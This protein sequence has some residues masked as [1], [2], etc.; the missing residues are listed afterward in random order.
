M[1]LHTF[2]RG[3]RAW[4]KVQTISAGQAKYEV[5]LGSGG[6]PKPTR[7]DS[8]EGL[9]V[10]ATPDFRR[11]RGTEETQAGSVLIDG[12]RIAAPIAT[13]DEVGEMRDV[14]RW[15]DPSREIPAVWERTRE[16]RR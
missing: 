2:G 10:E 8:R 13:G 1:A 16:H 12:V 7:G 3:A 11:D 4:D 15:I 9:E 6:S 14:R 5:P